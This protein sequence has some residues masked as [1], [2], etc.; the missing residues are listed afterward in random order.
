MKFISTVVI[1]GLLAGCVT[2]TQTVKLSEPW[3]RAVH[4]G[5][6]ERIDTTYSILPTCESAGYPDVFIVVPPK[7]GVAS[8]DHG[9][10]YPDFER[11]NVRYYCNSRLVPVTQIKYQSAPDFHGTDFFTVKII[12]PSH[13]ED[14]TTYKIDVY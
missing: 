10:D 9:E 4:S 8:V 3:L 5:Q 13:H 7:H 14:F 12:H 2:S 11:D 1:L 6:L